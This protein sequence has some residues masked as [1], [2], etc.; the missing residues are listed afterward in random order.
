MNYRMQAI[1]DAGERLWF[2]SPRPTPPGHSLLFVEYDKAG[3]VLYSERPVGQ[4][5]RFIGEPRGAGHHDKLFD[6]EP[7]LVLAWA[8]IVAAIGAA[9]A[10]L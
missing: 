7:V 9:G 4:P 5:V 8:A 3:R 10:W 1:K 2:P 6:W